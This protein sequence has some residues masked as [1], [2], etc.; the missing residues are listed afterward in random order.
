MY[1]KVLST[2][3][4][5][6]TEG[7]IWKKLVLYFLPIAAGTLFQQLYNAVDAIIVSRFV[8]TEALAAVGGS[9]AT[10]T[11]LIIGFFVALSSGAAVIIAQYFGSGEQ[12]KI[13]V[14]VRTS[15]L[16]CVGIG[17]ALTVIMLFFS[18]PILQLLNTPEETL[19]MA[20]VYMKIYFAGSIFLL[21]FNM[22]SGILRAIGD[23]RRPFIYLVV[24][25]LT[26][27]LLDLLFVVVFQWGVAGV[28]WATVI[29]QFVSFLL[30]L[31]RL[32]RAKEY[33]RLDLHSLTI[34]PVILKRMLAIG[35][36][37][38]MQSAMYGIS[39][40]ILQVG[41]NSLGT[42]VVA[43]WSMSGKLDGVYW[44]VSS[45]FGTAIMN[46]TAQNYGAKKL[47]RIRACA[48][49]GFLLF[50]GGTVVISL[51]LLAL[52]HPLLHI[53]T[54]DVQVIDT[55]WTIMLCFVPAYVLWTVVETLTGILRG[56]GDAVKPTI[57]T[58]LGVCLLRIIWVLTA[59]QFYPLL[60]VLCICYPI[61]W[62]VTDVALLLYYRRRSREGFRIPQIKEKAGHHKTVPER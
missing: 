31:I 16:L 59:F 5:D 48:K 24:S 57:I 54:T 38:G 46:F 28:A 35:I 60:V 42:V 61:S 27:I 2:D 17:A 47:D 10:L 44:A 21:V 53:F 6:L 20:S 15:V 58:A 50:L 56:I 23:S 52:A 1:K 32:L 40:I 41:V 36:P 14:A 43:S 13:T 4:N 34:N 11:Q 3:T 33:Y 9:P 7:V 8:G 25:C 51:L 12:D 22:G 49:T 26:N 29:A 39:N 18:A 37:S 19:S 30:V 55:T 45:A 62:L